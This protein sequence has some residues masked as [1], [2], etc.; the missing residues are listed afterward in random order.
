MIDAR[1]W[2]LFILFL[3]SYLRQYLMT[4][5]VQEGSHV[6]GYRIVARF[7][8]YSRRDRRKF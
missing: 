8:S 4:W 3:I 7:A 5:T 2:Q 1:H 6:Y